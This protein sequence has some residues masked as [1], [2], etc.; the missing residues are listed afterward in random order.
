MA[1]KATKDKTAWSDIQMFMG[2]ADEESGDM[3]TLMET[4]G[5]LDDQDMT[6][7][8]TDGTVYQLK[9]INQTLIDEL[10]FEPELEISTFLLNPIMST[11]AKFWEVE[12]DDTVADDLWVKSTITVEK[13]AVE[14][15]NPKVVGSRGFAAPICKATLSPGY[16]REKGWS[17]P[18][19]F[20][21][22]N[23]GPKGWF[24]LSVVKG[25]SNS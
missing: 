19:K 3:P 13:K 5:I 15:K 12:E 6:I 4:L 21:I 8:L 22:L 20:K 7:E 14:F 16:S 2:I 18:V 24:K 17:Y 11:I 25:A 23:T 1:I 10:E 9:D